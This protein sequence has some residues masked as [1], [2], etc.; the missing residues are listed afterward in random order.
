MNHSLLTIVS[1]GAMIT[2]AASSLNA[3][4]Q[5]SEPTAYLFTSFRGNGDGLH[6]AYSEDGREWVDLNRVFLTPTVGSKL[7]RDPQILLGP[8]GLYHMVWTSGWKDTGIGHATSKNLTDW[9]EQQYIPLMEKVPGTQ[10]CWAPELFYDDEQKQY[11][12]MWSSNVPAA[13]TGVAQ[14]R[15]YYSLTSDF[16]TFTDP[17]MLFDPG[18]DNIDTTMLRVGD[19]YAIAFKQTDDQPKKVW[20]PIHA[21][22]ADKPLGPYKLSSEP[23]VANQ[24]IEGPAL[25][26]LG[27]KTLLYADFYSD[28]RYGVYET[29]D[30]KSWKD[31]TSTTAVIPD[32][33]HGSIFAVPPALLTT[34]RKDEAKVIAGV[35]KP[36]LDGFTADPSI[37]VFGDT[38]YVYPTSDK[39]HWQTTDFS[40]WSS[41]N[42]IDWKRE[43]MILDVTKDLAWANIRAWAPD[44]IERDGKYYFYFC[45]DGKI[46]V[47]TADKP[48]GPFKDAL[49]KPLLQKG[50]KIKTNTIDPAAFIDD[51]GQAYL[52]FG[53]GSLMQVYK[54]KPDMVT[55]D[56]D[57][58]D[59]SLKEFR[60]GIWVF[61]RQGKYYFMWSIDDARSPNYRVG[62]GIADSPLGPVKPASTDFIVLQKNGAAIGTAHHSVVNVPGTDRWYVAYHRHAMLG[63]S[64]YKREVC[65]VRMEFNPDGTIKPMDPLTT[66]FAPGSPGEPIVNG[67]GAPDPK[68]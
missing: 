18:F 25:V 48:T 62:Y 44:C 67:K 34:L 39:P 13:G 68:R 8:D 29:A 64:G 21:A 14:H 41:K 42:L 23:P 36:I 17:K 27:G 65:L 52:Y 31:V 38:Y 7:L 37:R 22:M 24:R 11:I 66:P 40:V 32:Q 35:P 4:A 54:L 59:L 58:T 45:A 63:G 28:H 1:L 47:G 51:D 50:G 9:S 2:F 6:L 10:T 53:N 56:G 61:K 16:K 57:P 15:A 46:G 20:G 30:W 26:Q 12:I 5:T 3:V 55:L 19:R 33:R 49:G 43:G 60:E